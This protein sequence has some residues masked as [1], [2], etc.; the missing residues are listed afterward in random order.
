MKLAEKKV[1]ALQSFKPKN[2]KKTICQPQMKS[3]EDIFPKH[4]LK[5]K[6]KDQLNKFIK[7][8]Q[9]INKDN[10]VYKAG[11]TKQQNILIFFETFKTILSFR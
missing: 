10:L 6:A 3:T 5:N 1:E 8:E 11:N 9:E 4:L 7:N 2:K